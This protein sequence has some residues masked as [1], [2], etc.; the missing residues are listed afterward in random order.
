MFQEKRESMLST[1]PNDTPPNS[2]Q[3][4][5]HLVTQQL[6]KSIEQAA[7]NKH[8]VQ[9][10][11]WATPTVPAETS[12]DCQAYVQRWILRHAATI[13]KTQY[14]ASHAAPRLY[15]LTKEPNDRLPKT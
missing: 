10:N 15:P 12:T 7:T 4:E 11:Q 5:Y 13:Y 3:K 14:A 8:A 9:P 6:H 1:L 2:I